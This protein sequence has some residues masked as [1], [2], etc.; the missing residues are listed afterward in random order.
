MLYTNAQVCRRA[1]FCALAAVGALIVGSLPALAATTIH[2]GGGTDLGTAPPD[3]TQSVDPNI[4]VTFDDSG[5]MGNNYMGDNSPFNN[6]SWS[7]VWFCAGIIDP[8]ITDPNDLRSH[9]MNGVYYN[10]N[11][12]YSPPIEADGTVMPDADV[13]LT[14]VWNDGIQQN[15]PRSAYTS[16]TT[17]FTGVL[18]R[19][20]SGKVKSDKRWKCPKDGSSPL[21]DSGGPYYYRLKSGVNI[22][23]LSSVNTGNIVQFQQLGSGGRAVGGI[24]E[25]GQLVGILPDTKFDDAYCVVAAYSERWAETSV[26]PGRISTTEVSNCRIHQSSP[27]W[28]IQVSFARQAVSIRRLNKA[29]CRPRVTVAPFSTGYSRLGA[30]GGTP[31]RASTIRAGEFFERGTGPVKNLTNP[32]WQPPGDGVSGAGTGLQAKLPYAGYGRLLER[33]RPKPALWHVH[34][35]GKRYAFNAAGR[36][37]V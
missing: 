2:A 28:L 14:A 4:V 10:P 17:N 20:S 3:L 26:S 19:Y 30:N 33:R 24:S 34:L 22:G 37:R 18:T 27:I 25:L 6:G 16:G 36:N 5:S 32:Y 12:V 13:G 15:R 35:A 11:V 7:G 9:A 8:R 23:T 21:D 31:D 1:I 29:T